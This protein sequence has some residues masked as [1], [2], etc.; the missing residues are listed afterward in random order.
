MNEPSFIIPD[1][2]DPR[3]PR[4]LPPDA[5]HHDRAGRS[6]RHDAVHNVFPLF[7]NQ[8]TYESLERL[9]PGRRPFLLSRA[10]YLGVGRYSALWTGDN[11]SWWEHLRASLPTVA[12]I[13]L[14]GVPLAGVD[15][16]GFNDEVSPELFARWLAVG[17]LM[18]LCR[19]H[20]SIHSPHQEPY[21]FG[22]E[23]EALAKA[24]LRLRYALLPYLYSL[25]YAAHVG[26]EPIWR[27]L[28]YAFPDDPTALGLEDEV[29]VGPHLL[30]APV[31]EPAKEA[32]AV[33]LPAGRWYRIDGPEAHAFDGPSYHLATAPLG[34]LP[35]YAR[36]G[37]IVVADSAPADRTHRFERIHVMVVPGGEGTFTLFEDDGESDAYRSGALRLTHLG[38]QEAG[39]RGVLTVRR[40][41]RG[42]G[43]RL[44]LRTPPGIE[45]RAAS[46]RGGGPLDRDL[47]LP[48][49][50][51][52]TIEVEL[53]E[54]H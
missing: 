8:A 1:G 44:L 45:V 35:L 10:G 32:R 19:N 47:A 7:M 27:P 21:A 52:A 38:W 34:V 2:E 15:I 46:V 43:A 6:W 5:V 4:T 36:G 51:D 14:C 3:G 41:G 37:A 16:G 9:R 29:L 42:T 31:V 53:R 33:Y 24:H 49:G 54:Q 20:S 30:M 40:E 11:A 26:G 18:P 17:A 48:D 50:A 28:G 12:G 13:G 39:G 23:I 22:P 25:A